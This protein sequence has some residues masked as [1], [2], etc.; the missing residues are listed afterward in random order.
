MEQRV[1]I[2]KYLR[3]RFR[4]FVVITPEDEAKY[5]RE[6]FVPEFRRRSPGVLVP[7]LEES[8][9]RISDLLTEEK[10]SAN[11]ENFLDEAKRRSEIVVLSEV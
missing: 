11:I 10:V 1:K 8:R 5:Y 3:F 7:G 2:K 9:A 6:R 4:S